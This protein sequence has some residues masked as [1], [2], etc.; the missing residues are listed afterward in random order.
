MTDYADRAVVQITGGTA[1]KRATLTLALREHW[2]DT[3]AGVPTGDLWVGDGVT[4]GGVP[5]VNDQFVRK[6]GFPFPYEVSLSYSVSTR[7]V[8]ITPTG[9]TFDVWVGGVRFTKTGAQVSPAHAATSDDHF[10]Y[11]DSTGEIQTGTT[12]WDL[13]TDAPVLSVVYTAAG[14][15]LSGSAEAP[16]VLMEL[17]TATR[18]PQLHRRLHFGGGTQLSSRL[19]LPTIDTAADPQFTSTA[20]EILDEDIELTT[21]AL[22]VAFNNVKFRYGASGYWNEQNDDFTAPGDGI[23]FLDDGTDICWNEWTGAAWQKT[24]VSNNDYVNMYLCATTDNDSGERWFVVP[25]QA[26]YANQNDAENE[27]PSSLSWGTAPP[28]E[29]IIVAALV[30]SRK[31]ASGAGNHFA[32]IESVRLFLG[33]RDQTISS[34]GI[35]VHAALSGLTADDHTQYALVAGGTRN[36]TGDHQ[37]DGGVVVVGLLS[38]TGSFQTV[39]A[40][41]QWVQWD[42]SETD[43]DGGRINLYVAAGEK[44]DGTVHYQHMKYVEHDGASNDQKTRI[45]WLLNRTESGTGT[46]A[47][48]MRLD[49]N[50]SVQGGVKA[51]T[52]RRTCRYNAAATGIATGAGYTLI[53]FATNSRTDAGFTWNGGLTEVT[54][55]FTGWIEI[56]YDISAENTVS[57]TRCEGYWRCEVDTGGGFAALAGSLA[58]SYH[59]NLTSNLGLQTA[60]CRQLV[61]AVTSGDIFRVSGR[62]AAGGSLELVIGGCRVHVRRIAAALA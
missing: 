5:V 58:F 20:I 32:A 3:V 26:K 19:G 57:N 62:N 7:Q 37:F 50:L 13:L 35:T 53:P 55:G 39:S 60:S 61:V 38:A 29:F 36:F 54:V 42:T 25:G 21:D 1:A 17:H 34:G 24:A 43:V 31:V 56:G 51:F 27:D 47:E 9:S 28:E 48:L 33:N 16:W 44:G 4:L 8:T 15:S 18:D 52:T 41:P 23:P 14:D 11:Y 10:F 30:Y 2:I 46:P 49:D 40:L 45:R 12:P 6:V 59:R 22:T